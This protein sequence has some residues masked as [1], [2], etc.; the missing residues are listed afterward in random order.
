M[1]KILAVLLLTSICALAQENSASAP[2]PAPNATPASSTSA[3]TSAQKARQLLD[4][5]ITALGGPAWLSYKTYAQQG[6]SYSFYHGNPNSAGVL[7]WRFYE[8]PDK[9]RRELTKQRDIIYIFNDDK[10]FERTYKGTTSAEDKM[11]KEMIRRRKHSLEVVLREWLKDPKTML[12]YEGQTVADQQLVDVVS[13]LNKDDDQLTIGIDVNTH[14]PI[15]KRYTWRDA[16]KYKVEDETIYGN[17]RTVQGIATPFTVTNK[18]DGE[19]SGQSFLNHAEYNLA[20]APDFFEA[21]VNY[22]PETYN[23]KAKRK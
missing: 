4:Q 10:G 18:R 21:S 2:T 14:L 7:F 8:Y 13:I 6:R 5:M 17:Y 16:D 1:K 12:I 15:S 23:P 22:N 3:G 9:E 20:L 11:T 19:I